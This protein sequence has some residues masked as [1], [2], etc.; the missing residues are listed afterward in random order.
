MDLL[1]LAGV[2]FTLVMFVMIFFVYGKRIK[3]PTKCK[4]ARQDFS[5]CSAYTVIDKKILLNSNLEK[6]LLF[7][8]AVSMKVVNFYANRHKDEFFEC[9]GNLKKAF[10]VFLQEDSYNKFFDKNSNSYSKLIKGNFSGEYYVCYIKE[11]N[12]PQILKCG[13]LVIHEFIHCFLGSTSGDRDE[14][15]KFQ[16]IVLEKGKNIEELS[17]IAVQTII[18]NKFRRKN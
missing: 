14:E 10:F 2:F 8:C 5:W 11:N 9:K 7:V 18:E 4:V 15:H 13:N 16:Q 1:I 6:Q 3:F 12:I 17:N